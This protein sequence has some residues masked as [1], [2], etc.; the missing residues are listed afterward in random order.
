MEEGPISPPFFGHVEIYG[1]VLLRCSYIDK[2]WV[3]TDE[4]E[5]KNISRQ[6]QYI[7]SLLGLILGVL[8]AI[9]LKY[10]GH[11]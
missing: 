3:M 8:I 7:K 11:L 2:E 1:K 4:D 9:G 6:F 5:G 10:F